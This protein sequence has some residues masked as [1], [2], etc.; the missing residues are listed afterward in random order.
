MITQTNCPVCKSENF[1]EVLKAKDYTVSGE[2]F[3][4]QE[5]QE[6]KFRFTSPIPAED[7]IGK[8]YQS[9]E[10]ISHSNT[11]KGFINRV[12]QMV[13]NRT[14]KSKRNLIA[15]FAG[16]SSGSLLDIGC[17]TGEFLNTVKTAGWKTKGLEPDDGARGQAISNYKLDVESPEKLFELEQG[18]FDV[19][20][21]WHV[22]EH[23]H[24]LDA[25]MEQIFKLLKP[26]GKLIIAV[27]N[28][29]SHDA[30]KFG[31][32]WAAYDVPRHL[33]HF[34]KP[35]METLLGRFGF[36]LS[37]IRIMPFDSFYVSMLSARYRKTST[38]GGIWIGFVSWLGAIS[39]SERCS[40]IIYLIEKQNR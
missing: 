5:C 9:E 30:E 31:K 20:T 29:N 22:L 36:R 14:L 28:Y 4:V 13:R 10:Y 37:N 35:S 8:Y 24:R 7:A 11:S 23:V 18:Q 34:H 3:P 12:Y 32:F 38:I 27:P 39:K 17:G 25:Y 40:S 1:K 21:M 33:Y 15:K 26:D 16:T 19:I 2:I 6:C